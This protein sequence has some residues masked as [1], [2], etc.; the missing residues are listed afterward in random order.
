MPLEAKRQTGVPQGPAPGTA[1]EC[2]DPFTPNEHYHLEHGSPGNLKDSRSFT[3][4]N[5]HPV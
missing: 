5:G 1:A 3:L 4:H 2:G